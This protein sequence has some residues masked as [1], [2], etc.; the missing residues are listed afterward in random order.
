MEL[1]LR[2]T[3]LFT[4]WDHTLFW[5][6]TKALTLKDLILVNADT[7]A[8]L[9]RNLS[10]LFVYNLHA[11]LLPVF[12]TV[13]TVRDNKC[14]ELCVHFSS[15]RAHNGLIKVIHSMS[16]AHMAKIKPDS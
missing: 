15:G 2:N 9:V 13:Y 11:C 6:Q 16:S 3:P 10:K 14:N 1:L 12:R 7:A 8:A 4:H 5:V